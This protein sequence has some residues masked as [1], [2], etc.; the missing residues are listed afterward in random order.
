MN[1]MNGI[2]RFLKNYLYVMTR[3]VP[4]NICM[5]SSANICPKP[6]IGVISSKGPRPNVIHIFESIATKRKQIIHID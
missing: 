4:I 3:D 2:P 5:C 1:P 6:E